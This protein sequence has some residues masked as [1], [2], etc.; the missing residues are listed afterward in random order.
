MQSINNKVKNVKKKLRCRQSLIDW[1]GCS[2]CF[3]WLVLVLCL[4]GAGRDVA[5]TEGCL[6]PSPPRPVWSRTAARAPSVSDPSPGGPRD[7]DFNQLNKWNRGMKQLACGTGVLFDMDR[8]QSISFTQ[9]LCFYKV[10]VW[11]QTNLTI[12]LIHMTALHPVLLFVKKKKSTPMLLDLS[13]SE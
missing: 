7:E 8:A 12:F 4:S 3:F 2:E 11:S 6:K 9:L 5:W 1:L 13:K 10:R